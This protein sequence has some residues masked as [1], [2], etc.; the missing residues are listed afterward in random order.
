LISKGERNMRREI[1]V[2]LVT[3]GL[4]VLD[5]MPKGDIVGYLV[6]IDVVG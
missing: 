4:L 1:L 6:V 2:A 5:S 3:C